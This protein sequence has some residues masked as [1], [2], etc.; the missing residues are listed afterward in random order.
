MFGNECGTRRKSK[1]TKNMT[2][3]TKTQLSDGLSINS[4]A[5]IHSL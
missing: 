1:L 3:G 2:A 4:S 5:L